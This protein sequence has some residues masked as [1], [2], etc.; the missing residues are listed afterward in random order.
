MN[1]DEIFKLLLLILLLSNEKDNCTVTNCNSG[2]S[3]INEIIIITLLLN[4][5]SGNS[6]NNNTSP[7]AN[8]NTTF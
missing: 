7:T 2:F 6:F 5:C 3:N 8:T 1:Q 4:A